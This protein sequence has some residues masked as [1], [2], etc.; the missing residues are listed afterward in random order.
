MHF[1]GWQRFSDYADIIA[2]WSKKITVDHTVIMGGEP[3]LNPTI[4]EWVNGLN[5]IFKIDVGNIP[6]NEVDNYELGYN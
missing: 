6:T 2:E 4:V 3:L 1:R 5:R